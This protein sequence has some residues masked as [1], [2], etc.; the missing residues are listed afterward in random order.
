MFFFVW[1]WDIFIIFMCINIFVKLM[2][3][4]FF[5]ICFFKKMEV[6]CYFILIIFYCI[7]DEKFE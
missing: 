1:F 5:I 6:R 4:F 3:L 7:I 2:N